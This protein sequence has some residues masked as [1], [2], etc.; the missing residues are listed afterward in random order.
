MAKIKDRTGLHYGHWIVRGRDLEKSKETGKVYWDCECDCGCGTHRSLRT[1]ALYHVVVGGCL[2]M[3]GAT[4]KTCLKCGE[5]FIPK[6]Q[7]KTR[8]YCYNC[9]PEENYDGATIRHRIKLW[10]LE[11][12]GNQCELCGYNRC[13][14]AL[15]FHHLDPPQ[16]DFNLSD[17][18]IVLDWQ[19]VKKE[20]DKCILVCANCHREIHAEE[21]NEA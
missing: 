18:S 20:I 7:A 15:E 21:K 6:K 11:Y 9:V 1:D 3:S 5:N 13:S 12:K 2:N 4:T 8:K 10:S 19:S 17:R 16:K 14:D